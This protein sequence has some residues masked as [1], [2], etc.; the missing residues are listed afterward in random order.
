[1]DKT[2]LPGLILALV[3]LLGGA[4]MEGTTPDKLIMLP[5]FIIVFGA[6]GVSMVMEGSSP[7]SLLLPP[8]MILVFVGTFGAARSVRDAALVDHARHDLLGC[9]ADDQVLAVRQGEVGVRHGLDELDQLGIDDESAAVQSREGYHRGQIL[10]RAPSPLPVAGLSGTRPHG[11]PASY[12]EL[13]VL[14]ARSGERGTAPANWPSRATPGRPSHARPAAGCARLRHST[15]ARSISG[16][17]WGRV[18]APRQRASRR[19]FL[20][21]GPCRDLTPLGPQPSPDASRCEG[22]GRLTVA[23]RVIYY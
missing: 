1:M 13:L 19:D 14:N 9:L 8:A 22:D 10:S 4:M 18:P 16:T 5:A 12:Y 3:A 17:A 11:V 21:G 23:P 6:V 15:G 20:A 7:T 2:T